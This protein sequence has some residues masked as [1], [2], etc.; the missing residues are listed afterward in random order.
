MSSHDHKESM[1]D[2]SKPRL[3]LLETSSQLDDES[4]SVGGD[5]QRVEIDAT[6]LPLRKKRRKAAKKRSIQD[7]QGKEN[8]VSYFVYACTVYLLLKHF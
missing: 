4:L 7:S 6:P 2:L 8:T 5:E 3:P 1:L